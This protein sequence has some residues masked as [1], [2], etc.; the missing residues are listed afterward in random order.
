SWTDTAD[1]E[2]GFQIDAFDPS[3]TSWQTLAN[4]GPNV[5]TFSD[6]SVP[7]N[8]ERHYFV[9]TLS[10]AGRSAPSNLAMAQTPACAPNLLEDPSFEEFGSEAWQPILGHSGDLRYATSL[11]FH[12]NGVYLFKSPAQ[13]IEGIQQVVVVAGEPGDLIE[14]RFAFG[15]RDAASGTQ[16]G[17]RIQLLDQGA[18][19]DQEICKLRI[20]GDHDW[21]TLVCSLTASAIYDQIAVALGWQPGSDSGFL[22]F[23][24]VSLTQ[25]GP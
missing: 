24:Q 22:G 7:C 23:D 4:V 15:H 19:I 12:L 17:G 25:E 11:A 9:Y 3:L 21:R 13:G 5:T 16:V 1:N 18:V 2:L 20:S 10:E 8:T 6:S 14:L